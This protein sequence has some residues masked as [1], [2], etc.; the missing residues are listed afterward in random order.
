MS[1]TIFFIG[2]AFCLIGMLVLIGEAALFYMN[3]SNLYSQER[4]DKAFWQIVQ[5]DRRLDKQRA[6]NERSVA[7]EHDYI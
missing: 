3:R 4:Y 5:R 6:R 2:M 1:D 7:D